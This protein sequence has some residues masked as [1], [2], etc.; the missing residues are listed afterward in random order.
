[1]VDCGSTGN[2]SE[3]D[4]YLFK[5]GERF[6]N[7]QD[8]FLTVR[9]VQDQHGFISQVAYEG[10]GSMTNL[11]SGHMEDSKIKVDYGEFIHVSGKQKLQTVYELPHGILHSDQDWDPGTLFVGHD[12]PST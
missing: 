7:Q 12:H 3:S 6:A 9:L 10:K 11:S 1:M 8:D 5:T 4:V 2:L